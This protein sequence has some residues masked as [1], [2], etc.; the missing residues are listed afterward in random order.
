M[1]PTPRFW[2]IP[3][4][5]DSA[6]ADNLILYARTVGNPLGE[7]RSIRRA[8]RSIDPNVPVFHPQTLEEQLNNFLATD[9][10]LASCSVFFSLLAALL[11]ALG[12][13]DTMTYAVVSRTREI[14][15]RIALGADQ[16]DVI[17][18]IMVEI[19]A[20]LALGVSAGVLAAAGL[21]QFLASILFDIRPAD[22]FTVL[23]ASLF[24]AIIALVA[25]YLPARRA[26]RIDPTVALRYQ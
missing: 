24:M 18:P 3:Y 19:A 13:Y 26:A 10:M 16:A 20:M 9:R 17:W 2:Y 11:A 6:I 8:I 14:G 1:A 22:P 25:G 5:H 23:A 15:I 7:V 4:E 21:D 12:L